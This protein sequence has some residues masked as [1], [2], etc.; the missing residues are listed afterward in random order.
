MP[1]A[2][3]QR[4]LLRHLTFG[5]PSGQAVARAMGIEPLACDK[6]ED[7]AEFGLQTTTPLWFYI[8]REAHRRADGQHLGPVGGRI[9]AEVF[10]GLLLG[11][12]LSFL[13]CDP[14]WQPTLGGNSAFSIVDLLKI[15]AV[16]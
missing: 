10:V 8:L 4:N 12:R 16:V 14:H 13:R 1:G 2:L 7:L 3:A 5:L 9:V 11:D 15:A 6:L